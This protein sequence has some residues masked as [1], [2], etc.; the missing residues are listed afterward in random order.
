MLPAVAEVV[1][2]ADACPY[3]RH[4][5]KPRLHLIPESEFTLRI[6]PVS[7]VADP[8][9]VQ[10]IILPAHSGLD[11]LVQPAQRKRRTRRRCRRTRPRPVTGGND[12]SGTATCRARGIPFTAPAPAPPAGLPWRRPSRPQPACSR[13]PRPSAPPPPTRH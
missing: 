3:L 10:M 7:G 9:D 13:P 1:L 4:I 11:H 6:G 5:A 2:V 8:E 12:P